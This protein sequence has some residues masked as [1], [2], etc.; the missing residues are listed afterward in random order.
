MATT[1]TTIKKEVLGGLVCV[2]GN[3][4]VIYSTQTGD[5]NTGLRNIV[6]FQAT[7]ISNAGTVN[8]GTTLSISSFN[9]TGTTG[10]PKTGATVNIFCGST[11]SHKISW[12]A[13]GYGL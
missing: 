3:T 10:F 4:S 11:G 8:T 6:G 2:V 12:L 13:L 9:S 1:T 7:N 5:I